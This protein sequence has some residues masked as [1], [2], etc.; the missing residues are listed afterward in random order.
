MGRPR[1]ESRGT[2]VDPV[3]IALKT[4]NGPGAAAVATV[5]LAVI[6]AFYT[7]RVVTKAASDD[8]V[9]AE[10]RATDAA[11]KR[12]DDYKAMFDE[13]GPRFDALLELAERNTRGRRT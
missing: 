3:D 9:A 12:G 2:H 10:Q 13:W 7:G 5:L 11:L 1:V 8:R 6:V 4:L